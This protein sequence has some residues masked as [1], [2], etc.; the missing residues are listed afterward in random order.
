MARPDH[1]GDSAGT[2]NRINRELWTEL[3]M[4]VPFPALAEIRHIRQRRNSKQGNTELKLEAKILLAIRQGIPWEH[5]YSHN[6][7]YIVSPSE[8]GLDQLS[9]IRLSEEIR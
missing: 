8:G 1:F 2:W 7:E 4:K 3:G 5:A 9:N 6:I